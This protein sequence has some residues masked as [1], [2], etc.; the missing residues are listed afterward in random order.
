MRTE[1]ISTLALA[2]AF[3]VAAPPAVAQEREYST[4]PIHLREFFEDGVGVPLKDW[5]GGPVEYILLDYERDQWEDL[6][7]DEER[8][9]FIEWFWARR[10][11]DQRDTEHPFRADFYTR[12]AYANERFR[13]FPRGWRSDRG[14]AYVT[15]GPPSGGSR[16]IGL[17]DPLLPLGRCY[18][19]A[20]YGEL[21]TYY[22]GAV[23]STM[24]ELPVL[25]AEV[26]PGQFDI[27]DPG[28][29]GVGGWPTYVAQFMDFARLSVIQD[30]A[31]G[32]NATGG[33]TSTTM[34]VRDVVART[35][36]L[37]VPMAE[38]GN[39]GAAGMAVI[40]VE[41]P[42]RSLLFEPGESAL[43]A[44]LVAEVRLV[45]MGET[46]GD[47]VR[48]EWSLAVGP[49]DANS[50]AGGALRTALVVPAAPGGYSV[51][52]R[53][54]EPISGTA[55]TWEGPVEIR[56]DG[57]AMSPPIVSRKTF[58]LRDAGEIGTVGRATARLTSGEPFSILSWVRGMNLTA[59]DVAATIFDASG[60]EV[61][62]DFELEWG[63]SG[64]GPL[65]LRTVAPAAAPGEYVLRLQV[66]TE[67]PPVETRVRF[68]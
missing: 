35:E 51:T 28:F 54:I 52:A 19:A 49:E 30:G 64:A 58:S 34:E 12:V 4:N 53:I 27:C 10:D 11:L 36:P 26:R 38:W 66:G 42:L 18:M 57:T 16:R 14:R 46:E 13:G 9:E 56:A 22:T 39:D 7:T 29:T 21:W 6:N 3:S 47:V 40:P 24:G 48:H 67:L 41:L 5:D 59:D 1:L 50:I 68:E 60:N 15:L 61:A 20:E 33:S 32:F 23:G 31:T 62:L 2:A 25:F 17:D 55:W 37:E 45:G 65:V 44:S 63:D 8:I 43:V